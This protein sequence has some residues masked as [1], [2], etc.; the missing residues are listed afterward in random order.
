MCAE[1]AA[2]VVASSGSSPHMV[3]LDSV[4]ASVVCGAAEWDGSVHAIFGVA[5]LP[6]EPL[7]G[8]PWLLG[9][10]AVLTNGVP[11]LRD[12]AAFVENWQRTWPVLMNCVDARHTRARRWLRWL[13][14]VEVARHETY[15]AAGIPFIQFERVRRV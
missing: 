3:L 2:E 9:S 12:S 10:D 13:G 15:G 11:F 4:D 1:D 5:P 8:V 14:F 7:V 6:G